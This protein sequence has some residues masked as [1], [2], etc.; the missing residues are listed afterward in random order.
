MH[1]N[2]TPST[3]PVSGEET[4]GRRSFATLER[5]LIGLPV[6][7]LFFMALA[8]LRYG[9]D[10]P[11]LDDFR[12]YV[13]GSAASFEL[14]HLFKSENDTLS[15]TTRVLDAL[16]QR[17]LDGNSIAYQLLSMLAV[18]GSLL[19]LQWKLLARVLPSRLLAACAF[20]TTLLML[21]P[22]SYWGWQNMAYV[23]AIP[24]VCVFA[25]LYLVTC[26]AWRPAL[27]HAALFTVALVSGLS[28]ISGAFAALVLGTT[29]LLA[30]AI[31]RSL[32]T[33][34]G[35]AGL[36][37]LAGG[38]ITTAVQLRVIMV[39]QHGKTHRADAAW[40]LPT[41]ADFWFYLLGKVGRSLMFPA[42]AGGWSLGLAIVSL[43]VVVA[44]VGCGV[45]RLLRKQDG[46]EVDRAVLIIF[47]SLVGVVAS[48]LL[49]VAAGRANLR[50]ASVDTDIQIF[51]FGYRRFHFFW[52]TAL[53][54]WVFA[55]AF[56]LIRKWPVARGRWVSAG[57][58]AMA[59][60]LSLFALSQGAMAH[61]DYFSNVSA[62]RSAN[63]IPC[64]QKSLLDESDMIC[65]SL[66]GSRNLTAAYTYGLKTGA[67]FTR[68]FPPM[69]LAHGKPTAA[70]QYHPLR[71]PAGAYEIKHAEGQL[72]DSGKLSISA[73]KDVNVYFVTGAKRAMQECLALR[74][75]AD[76]T[77]PTADFA[78]L[79][80]LPL[81]EPRFKEAFSSKVAVP[82][83]VSTRVEFTV[84]SRDGFRDRFRLDPL[85][86]PNASQ[87][88]NL[89]VS[90]VR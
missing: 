1:E 75:S 77:T 76:I 44:L 3:T 90:C 73:G 40:A 30:C 65:P 2:L 84:V 72:S 55:A 58:G 21:Q 15:V 10:L 70:K 49:M 71:Q 52:V 53:W 62:R 50:P 86:K 26:C 24:L 7:S 20:S 32:W 19:W 64:I 67:S 22:D 47:L 87:V 79:F 4:H 25:M 54:P 89:S 63:D 28:Y 29:W 45:V 41:D 66:F 38:V 61:N 78:Q 18:L 8:W 16:A 36:A 39:V 83:Q 74:V 34:Y 35:A 14:S 88:A 27:K 13:T 57:M 48:Y 11:Y 82:G 31:D 59:V 33:K 43:L 51:Q 5:V 9:I 12:A 46:A 17:Y 56:V 81:G 85:A 6:I 23:Q 60:V 80:Y 68:Y 42:S 37:V 69:L